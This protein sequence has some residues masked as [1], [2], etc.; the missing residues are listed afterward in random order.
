MNKLMALLLIAACWSCASTPGTEKFQEKRNNIVN[1]HDKV[2]E[3]KTGRVLIDR[4]AQLYSLGDYLIICDHRSYDKQV[5]L[6]DINYFGYR[7][8]TA[9]KGQGPYEI[10]NI[11]HIGIDE[12]NNTFFVTDHG[13]QK[14]FAYQIDSLLA[15]PDCPPETKLNFKENQS[16]A[17][18]QFPS[19]YQYVNDTLSFCRLIKPT[20]NS[21]FNEVVAK[22]NMLTG[23]MHPMKYTH[24]E[25]EKRRVN[26]AASVK[27]GIY[28]ECYSHHDL[29]TIC[30]LDGELKYNIYGSKWNN[31][32]SNKQCYYAGV[33]FC[34]DRIVATN[35][36]GRDNF[37]KDDFYPTEF[38]VFDT[39]GNYIQTLETGYKISDFCFDKKNNRI[40]MSLDDDIQFAY[41][42]LNGVMK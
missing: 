32:K 5:H 23:E 3:I 22:W 2:K 4:N 21:G 10:T 8:G 14:V 24:P 29:M 15:N 36:C 37:S 19:Q 27:H 41:L 7:L 13:K 9:Y 28:V 34:N 40:I 12:A 17:N 38:L 30:T 33:A 26:M 1:V 39:N 11:G 20:G 18:Y 25:I 31:E 42:N 6:F 16:S 35:S